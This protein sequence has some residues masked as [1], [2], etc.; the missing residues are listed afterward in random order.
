LSG[1]II[2]DREKE[3]GYGFKALIP[4][5]DKSWNWAWLTVITSNK[6]SLRTVHSLAL[7]HNHI[8]ILSGAELNLSLLGSFGS[9]TK[10]EYPW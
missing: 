3:L 8:G 10:A 5:H 1:L 4:L 9:R 2:L 7:G 6:M